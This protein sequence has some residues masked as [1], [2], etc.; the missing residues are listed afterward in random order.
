MVVVLVAAGIAIGAGWVIPFGA[1]T[2]A[3]PAGGD[4]PPPSP[5]VTRI[6]LSIDGPSLRGPPVLSGD[7][8]QIAWA[9]ADGVYVRSLERLEERTIQ[10][11]EGGAEQYLFFSPDGRSLGFSVDGRLH[12]VRLE[13]G[14]PGAVSDS[15]TGGV[16][17]WSEEGWIYVGL[18][19]SMN[20]IRI[21]EDG[22]VTEPVLAADSSRAFQP[23]S[24]V[25]GG[26]IL[27]TLLVRER[28]GGET[29]EELDRR[30][31][32]WIQ[33]PV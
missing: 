18:R 33:R 2:A 25:V 19:E 31:P 32:C 8:R 16:A 11:T 4:A 13:G 22:S 28:A 26:G 6:S 7:G 21:R 24:G 17:V 5:W 30:W 10:G 23:S 14:S 20:V 3:R 29:G 27:G 12:T 1:A 9:T 15:V